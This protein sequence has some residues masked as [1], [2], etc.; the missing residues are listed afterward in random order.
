MDP[1]R[2]GDP[3]AGRLPHTPG[4]PAFPTLSPRKREEIL[5][6]SPLARPGEGEAADQQQEAEQ[7]REHRQYADAAYDARFA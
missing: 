7:A 4:R 3:K 6:S 5:N 2:L 1:D